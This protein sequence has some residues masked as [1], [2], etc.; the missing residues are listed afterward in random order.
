M[1]TIFHGDNQELSRTAF[2]DATDKLTGFDILQV[3]A[4]TADDNQISQFLNSLS[5]ISASKAI[6][7]TNFFSIP[8]AKLDKIIKVINSSDSN[9]LIWQD[10]QL[11]PAQLKLLPQAKVELFKADNII[12][13]CLNQIK[14]KNLV[15]FIS[16]YHQVIDN[17]LYDLLLYM[18]KNNLRQKLTSY[19]S[20]NPDLLKKTYLQLI[21]LDY[22][23]KSG[24]LAIAKE[25]ALE[26]LMIKLLS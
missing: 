3:D 7:F 10:K 4:K 2:V 8:K 9:V 5:F 6:C 12:Y 25:I 24:N 16:Y 20:F 11:T 13:L 23:N 18:L 1:I 21:E 15:K 19:S 26:R 17:G 22:Q 14:P